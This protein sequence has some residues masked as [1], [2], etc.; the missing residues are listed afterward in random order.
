MNQAIIVRVP[1]QAVGK[2]RPRVANRGPHASLYTPEKTAS[3]ESLV[4]MAGQQAMAGAD[5]ILVAV[6]VS[7]SITCQ[8]PAS[9]SKRKQ[10]QA[11][12]GDIRPTSKP[13]IDNVVKV[14]F[15]GLNGIVWKDD[16]QVVDTS[17]R[18]RYGATPG[19]VMT[20]V[21][22]LPTVTSP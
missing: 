18:K 13:D 11:L 3:Y 5:L 4:K 8:I 17:A 21:E 14:L 16:V 12:A 15:D 2:G 19:V 1:G 22:T 20:I 10:A 7:I 6:S 9:W